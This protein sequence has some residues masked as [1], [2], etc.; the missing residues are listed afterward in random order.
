MTEV[1]VYLGIGSNID[2]PFNV[3]KALSLLQ[4][5][6]GEL[7]QSPIYQN[8]AEGF[9]GEDFLNLVVGFSY[10]G[11]L[12]GLTDKL[13][14]IEQQCG[15]QRHLETGK[16]SRTLDLDVLIF[17]EQEGEVNGMLLPRP[18]VFSRQFV[19]QPLLD[20][21]AVKTGLSAFEKKISSVLRQ[22]A[23]SLNPMPMRVVQDLPL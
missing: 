18:D 10:A 15:R 4:A 9:D 20:L 5:E 2:A 12:S 11:P 13:Q 22:Q 23:A 6:L 16:G 3:Q 14:Q 19:W 21:L 7:Q 1:Q 8:S 17:G